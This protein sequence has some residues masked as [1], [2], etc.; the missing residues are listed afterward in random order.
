[1]KASD[2][3]T[4]FFEKMKTK[5]EKNP[6]RTNDMTGFITACESM[7]K[8]CS[9]I[10][11]QISEMNESTQQI[12]E[13]LGN[14]YSISSKCQYHASVARVSFQNLAR[15]TTNTSLLAKAFSYMGESISYFSNLLIAIYHQ[16][17]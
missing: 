6:V 1:M 2:Q 3:M 16:I 12:Y 17:L 8:N 14:V 4:T 9:I 7:E 13:N 10:D 5:V 15:T 11:H